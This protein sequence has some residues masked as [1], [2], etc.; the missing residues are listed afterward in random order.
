MNFKGDTTHNFCC[1]SFRMSETVSKRRPLGGNIELDTDAVIARLQDLPHEEVLD[2]V[3]FLLDAAQSAS[4]L[5]DFHDALDGGVLGLYFSNAPYT[6][7][8]Q[9]AFALPYH[10]LPQFCRVN[11]AAAEICES[12]LFW[13]QRVEQDFGKVAKRADTWK[14]AYRL[15][16]RNP[17]DL[18]VNVDVGDEY[19]VA[20]PLMYTIEEE[21]DCGVFEIVA[22]KPVRDVNLR[23]IR[24]LYFHGPDGY[25]A[26]Y[27]RPQGNGNDF[28][29][30]D[31]RLQ[32]HDEMV[33]QYLTLTFRGAPLQAFNAELYGRLDF[34]AWLDRCGEL[35]TDVT[36]PWPGHVNAL[37]FEEANQR[38][39]QIVRDL[40]MRQ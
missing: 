10:S 26:V 12:E 29:R 33:D 35:E 31:M 16:V 19:L 13:R 15:L 39:Q 23:A 11:K 38:A 28:Q 34:E 20:F 36:L 17:R 4:T 27:R 30:G 25:P 32:V 8:S 5:S 22:R 37:T 3:R 7:L 1:H 21:D 18:H 6:V 14:Q 40:P 24:A 9:I 2:F